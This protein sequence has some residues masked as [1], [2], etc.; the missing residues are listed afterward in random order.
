MSMGKKE[1]VQ[2]GWKSLL[3]P[4]FFLGQPD[5]VLHP[6]KELRAVHRCR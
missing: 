3:F 1:S 6:P 2:Q 5:V 4:E